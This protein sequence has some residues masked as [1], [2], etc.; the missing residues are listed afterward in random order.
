MQ[1]GQ[2]TLAFILLISAIIVEIAVFGSLIAFYSSR[3]ALSEQL[4]LQALSAAHSGIYDF[5]LRLVR[6]KELGSPVSYDFQVDDDTVYV[7][8]ERTIDG[9]ANLY[10]YSVTSKGV[11]RGRERVLSAEIIVDRRTGAVSLVK[12]EE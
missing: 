3:T 10:I 12:L 1:K 8:A 2:A 9:V 5:Q 4:N 11:S 7:T 6:N